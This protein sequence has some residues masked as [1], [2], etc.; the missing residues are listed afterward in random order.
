[1]S[2]KGQTEPKRNPYCYKCSKEIPG[3][4][5]LIAKE[6]NHKIKENAP[7]GSYGLMAGQLVFSFCPKCRA[8]VPRISGIWQVNA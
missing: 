2:A 1:M 7:E 5:L 3:E 4:V 6:T 8:L